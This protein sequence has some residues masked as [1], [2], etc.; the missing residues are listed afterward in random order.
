MVAALTVLLAA[1]PVAL[2]FSDTA[3]I[4]A[5]TSHRSAALETLPSGLKS[6][7][8]LS[9]L[10]ANNGACESDAIVVV[11][12]PGLH[13]SDLRNLSPSSPLSL[14]LRDSP[15]SR[16]YPY[17]SVSP[18]DVSVI[19][20]TVSS[21]CKSRLVTFTPGQ[22]STTLSPGEKYVINMR[23]P[24]LEGMALDRHTSLSQHIESLFELELSNIAASFPNH[25]VL[26]SG[27]TSALDKRQ[28]PAQTV[29]TVAAAPS[30]GILKRYQLLT[31]ALISV[32]LVTLFV[33]FPLLF[34]GI[35]ALSSIQS[36]LRVEAP[37]GYSDRERKNQ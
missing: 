4:V 30:G 5:W 3:P 20:E 24:H 35:T 33:L 18:D 22:P 14:V 16:Q 9:Y 2:A 28:S 37:K 17:V 19:V 1:L 26:Y 13:A 34:L 36:P 25:L 7:A 10:L 8:A 31:P 27:S 12:H 11:E 15:S 32:L 21:R 6:G 23:L 29:K